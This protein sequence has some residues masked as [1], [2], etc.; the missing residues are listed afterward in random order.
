MFGT[1]PGPEETAFD[2]TVYSAEDLGVCVR[3]A[4]RGNLKRS[5]QRRSESG[6]A[7]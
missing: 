7:G 6:G 3:A 1:T 2:S 4:P 5:F